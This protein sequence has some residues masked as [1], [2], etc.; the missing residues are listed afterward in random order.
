VVVAA[1]SVVRG[2]AP[3]NCVLAGAPARV[4]RRWEDGSGWEPP[5][6]TPAPVPPP[7]GVTAGQLRALVE[8]GRPVE[9]GEQPAGTLE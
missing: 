5:L 2:E 9:S 7:E 3:D 6:R 4:V 8:S 1:G